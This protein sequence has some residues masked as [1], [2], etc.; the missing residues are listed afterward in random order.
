MSAFF[1]GKSS[2]SPYI[3]MVWRGWVEKDYSPTCPADA[4]WNLLL[5]KQN[6]GVKVTVEGPTT[7]A[8]FKNQFEGS[9]FLVIK[10]KLGTFIPYL[11]VTNL[12]NRDALLPGAASQSFWLNGSAWQFPDYENAETF[13]DRLVRHDLLVV[14]LVVK[15]ALQDQPQALSSRTVRRRFLR[16]TGLTL[17]SIRQIERAQKA[18]ALLEQ[19]APILDAVYQLGYA[20]QPHMTRALKRF[21]GQTPAQIARVS[22][23]E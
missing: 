1:E 14:D 13:V 23:L 7:R 17:G 10:F 20:D 9:E 2:D 5:S 12:L 22:Q 21:I 3:H 8:I 19:G 18:S 6:G 4:Q 16:A 11:P 15:A